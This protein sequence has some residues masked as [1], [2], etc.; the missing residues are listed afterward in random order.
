MQHTP[1]CWMSG[2]TRQDR[3]WNE[4][5]REEVDVAP[6]VDKMAVC[7]LKGFGHVWRRPI[8]APIRGV[9]QMKCSPI[10]RGRGIP[11]KTTCGTIKKYLDFNGL[12]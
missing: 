4:Y 10:A 3:N 11:T 9:D 12:W 5:I 7:W 2:H 6:I 1:K 8:E